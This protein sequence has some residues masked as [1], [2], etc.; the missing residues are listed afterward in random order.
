MNT[1]IYFEN[2]AATTTEHDL[3]ELFGPYGNI[4]D[5]NMAVDRADGRLCTFGFVTMVTPEGAQ[6]AVEFLNGKSI[7]AHTIVVTDAFPPSRDV[8]APKAHRIPRRSPSRL[9]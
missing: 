5:V 1:K 4:A 9:Y 3:R 8:R 2:F 7:G 6:A